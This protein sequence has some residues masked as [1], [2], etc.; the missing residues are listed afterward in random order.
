MADGEFLGDETAVGRAEDENLLEPETGR[1]CVCVLG[2]LLDAQRAQRGATG[3]PVAPVVVVHEL[4]PVGQAV[5]RRAEVGVVEAQPA[6][7]D[8]ARRPG[9]EGLV[10]QQ[11]VVHRYAGHV[12]ASSCASLGRREIAVGESPD[13]IWQPAPTVPT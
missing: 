9:T 8:Q 6:V 2:Q 11:R 12:A 13:L 7:H 10:V 1:E 5:D 3:A 4:Q